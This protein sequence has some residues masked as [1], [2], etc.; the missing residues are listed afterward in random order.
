[1]TEAVS[2]AAEEPFPEVYTPTG[3]T[4]LLFI[5]CLLLAEVFWGVLDVC[6]GG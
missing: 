5:Y 2:P 6:G 3:A 1:M 4:F